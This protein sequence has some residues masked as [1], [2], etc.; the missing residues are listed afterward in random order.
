MASRVVAL[1][2]FQKCFGL[3]KP[4]R[5]GSGFIELLASSFHEQPLNAN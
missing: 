1:F 5:V 2:L 4:F 3:I